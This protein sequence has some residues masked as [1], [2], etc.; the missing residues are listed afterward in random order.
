MSSLTEGIFTVL[1]AGFTLAALALILSPKAQTASVAQS[2]FSGEGNV[3]LAATSPVTGN[4]PA[5]SLGYPASNTL[6]QG[7]GS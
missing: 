6:S 4:A 3:I 7:F 5:G 2:I 1:L